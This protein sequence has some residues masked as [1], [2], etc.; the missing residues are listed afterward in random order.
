MQGVHRKV[1]LKEVV[2]ILTKK[3]GIGPQGMINV[4]EATKKYIGELMEGKGY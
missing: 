2:T 3:S 1:R 4:G